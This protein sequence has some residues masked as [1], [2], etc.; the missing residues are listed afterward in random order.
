M[1]H[2]KFTKKQQKRP[3]TPPVQMTRWMPAATTHFDWIAI[4]FSQLSLRRT[5]QKMRHKEQQ[6]T[7]CIRRHDY[8][9]KLLFQTRPANPGLG[10]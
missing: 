1:T 7:N 5:E 9:T 6:A 8:D 10:T 2:F 3:S 4:P